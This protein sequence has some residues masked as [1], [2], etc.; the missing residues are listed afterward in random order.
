[1]IL[2]EPPPPSP[3]RPKVLSLSSASPHGLSP[4]GFA[5]GFGS[6]V[7]DL[8]TVPPSSQSLDGSL[9]KGI[10]SCGFLWTLHVQARSSFG[11]VSSSGSDWWSSPGFQCDC[12][13]RSGI[14]ILS[15]FQASGHFH[16]S[17]SVLQVLGFHC[18]CSSLE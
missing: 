14:P 9:A 2:S 11:W 15:F 13:L 4:G 3:P 1:M 17:T 10:S 8:A 5:I 16:L 12:S 18:L 7:Q 6:S